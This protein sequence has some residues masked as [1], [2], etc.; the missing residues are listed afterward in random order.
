MPKVMFTVR[1][2]A[3]LVRRLRLAALLRGVTASDLVREAVA[4]ATDAVLDAPKRRGAGR[5]ARHRG[6]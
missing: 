3:R 1:L 6:E 5:A 2:P 4:K